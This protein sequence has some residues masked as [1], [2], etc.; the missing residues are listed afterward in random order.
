MR[1]GNLHE[2]WELV[3]VLETMSEETGRGPFLLSEEVT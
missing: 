3:F 2:G 1:S